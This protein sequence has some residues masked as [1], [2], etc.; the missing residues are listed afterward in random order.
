MPLLLVIVSGLALS[1]RGRGEKLC[2][3]LWQPGV[4]VRCVEWSLTLTQRD[5][6]G[7][8]EGGKISH[9]WLVTLLIYLWRCLRTPNEKYP[10]TSYG[11][12]QESQ[13][14]RISGGDRS[15]SD[16]LD[17]LNNSKF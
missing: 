4:G 16:N 17:N 15:D 11:V 7:R 12:S 10:K 6:R 2:I 3:A 1:D 5:E 14:T 8:E 13:F 9:L